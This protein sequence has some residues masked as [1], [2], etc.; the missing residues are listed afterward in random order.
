MH[1]E[2]RYRRVRIFLKLYA[3]YLSSNRME[4][5]QRSIR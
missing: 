3:N 1:Y 5:V 2:L 4:V